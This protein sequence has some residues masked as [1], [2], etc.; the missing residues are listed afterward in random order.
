MQ[1]GHWT[2]RYPNECLVLRNCHS[3]QLYLSVPSHIP[4]DTNYILTWKITTRLQANAIG[5]SKIRSLDSH[6]VQEVPFLALYQKALSTSTTKISRLLANQ[7]HAITFKL[8]IS[9]SDS[10][11][12]HAEPF[13]HL[14]QIA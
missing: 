3:L 6:P 10:R 5:D 11:S 12:P 14:C 4:T 8:A 13:N 2:M 9:P 1:R 7:S